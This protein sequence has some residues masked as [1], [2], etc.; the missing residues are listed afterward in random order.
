ML[1]YGKNP[2]MGSQD[3][4]TVWQSP[5]EVVDCLD[6]NSSSFEEEEAVHP[7]S[8][9]IIFKLN[10]VSTR[11]MNLSLL[12]I[13]MLWILYGNPSRSTPWSSSY[14]LF[15]NSPWIFRPNLTFFYAPSLYFA[16]PM[17]GFVLHLFPLGTTCLLVALSCYWFP[18]KTLWGKKLLWLTL[19]RI[20]ASLV[21]IETSQPCG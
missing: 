2:I 16:H 7:W 12:L 10:I 4:W 8:W 20:T 9:S 17:Q 18:F 14:S 15:T 5:W 13:R 21:L 6:F 11:T 1:V 3:V 19:N